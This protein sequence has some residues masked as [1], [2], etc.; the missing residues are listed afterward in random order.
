MNTHLVTLL[1]AAGTLSACATAPNWESR[2]G[3][4]N[5]QTLAQQ[6]LDPN[7][8]SRPAAPPRTDGKATSGA[9][10]GYADSF[11]YSVKE[12]RQTEITLAAPAAK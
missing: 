3:D 6:V 10:K 11:G 1:V 2:F 4:A 9:M 12:A 8:P 7:A 5:R